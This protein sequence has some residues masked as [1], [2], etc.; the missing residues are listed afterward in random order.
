MLLI[1][2]MLQL[3]LQM[4]LQLA[5][6]VAWR[7]EFGRLSATSFRRLVMHAHRSVHIPGHQFRA[8]IPSDLSE[9]GIP[10]GLSRVIL[11]GKPEGMNS[12]VSP[13]DFG[14]RLWMD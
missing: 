12:G 7:F 8:G 11:L 13:V 4:Y 3:H 2:P 5:V 10:G 6:A 14:G 1:R 9:T